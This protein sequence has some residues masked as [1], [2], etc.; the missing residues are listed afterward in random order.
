MGVAAPS[1]EQGEGHQEHRA[2]DA[3]Q[4]R[5][6][7]GGQPAGD[8]HPDDP[9]DRLGQGRQDGRRAGCRCRRWDRNGDR[10]AGRPGDACR[11]GDAGAEREGENRAADGC[12]RLRHRSRGGGHP[13]DGRRERGRRWCVPVRVHR[14][15]FDEVRLAVAVAVAAATP[16]G[17]QHRSGKEQGRD[18]TQDDS[19]RPELSHLFLRSLT[20]RRGA[21]TR[22]PLR[23]VKGEDVGGRRC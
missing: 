6:H 4:H 23:D 19:D 9:A 7:V 18:R 21:S 13:R 17:R 16:A 14:S 5:Q 3:E 2:E 15:E 20:P 10:D 8:E 1:D 22:R 11:P 12:R